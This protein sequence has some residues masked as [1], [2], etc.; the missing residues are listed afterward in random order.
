MVLVVSFDSNVLVLPSVLEPGLDL[1]VAKTKSS[2]QAAALLNT[3]VDQDQFRLVFN[4]R[5]THD[6]KIINTDINI[7]QQVLR[8]C[9]PYLRIDMV[10]TVSHLIQWQ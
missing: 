5:H 10:D 8:R 2:R 1:G 6:Q 4:G 7:S 3:A 9:F